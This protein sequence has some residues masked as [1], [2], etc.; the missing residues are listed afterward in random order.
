MTTK[1]E[2]EQA[3]LNGD[4]EGIVRLTGQLQAQAALER[5]QRIA[6]LQADLEALRAEYPALAEAS[7]QGRTNALAAHD[8]VKDAQKR[9]DLASKEAGQ[10]EFQ[11]SAQREAI[12]QAERELA[13]LVA[14]V[15]QEASVSDVG[16]IRDLTKARQ[17]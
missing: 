3:L 13:E 12:R 17:A 5:A 16:Y 10:I 7:K 2:L 11:A 15:R 14:E 9:A 1:S 6:K 8:A 4:A